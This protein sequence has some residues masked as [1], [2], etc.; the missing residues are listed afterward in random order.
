Q[1]AGCNA[2]IVMRVPTVE[3]ERAD[4]RTVGLRQKLRGGSYGVGEIGTQLSEVGAGNLAGGPLLHAAGRPN[5]REPRAAFKDAREIGVGVPIEVQ[6]SHNRVVA[7]R[8]NS[9]RPP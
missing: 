6:Q 5:T 3:R 1:P 4:A 7:C 8:Q 2:F 9:P